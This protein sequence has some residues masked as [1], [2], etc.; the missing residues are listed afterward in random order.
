[1]VF[2]K[3]LIYKS[4]VDDS[5]STKWTSI[6]LE[7]PYPDTIAMEVMPTRQLS[8]GLSVIVLLQTKTTHGI[9]E[10]SM[11]LDNGQPT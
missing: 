2:G 8:N 3:K 1:M 10:L 7:H 4:V 6:T 9:P 5:S 11:N